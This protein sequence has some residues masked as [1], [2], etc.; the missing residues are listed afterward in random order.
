MEKVEKVIFIGDVNPVKFLGVNDANLNFLKSRTST[1][2]I[3]RG[4][5][6]RL[7]GNPEEVELISKVIYILK[8]EIKKRGEIEDCEVKEMMKWGLEHGAEEMGDTKDFIITPKRRIELKTPNQK[9][10]IKLIDENDVVI[11]IGP[12][13]TGKTYLAVASAINFLRKNL[14]ERVILT[15]PAVEAG[16]SLGFLPGDFQEKINPYLTPLYDALYAL[17]TPE[18]IK[19]YIDTRVIEIAPL[20]YMRGRTFSDAF[21]ILDEAQNSKAVQMKMFLTRLG[22]R[23]K[24]VLTG[25]I[26][27]IDLPGNEASGLVEIQSVLKG[28]KGIAFIYFTAEDVV[29]HGLV[30]DIVNAYE[31]FERK[32]HH[33]A[34]EKKEV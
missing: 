30:K 26:T 12:A 8:N 25:D 7:R 29:R 9:E 3:V 10:Y 34:Q 15:R 1:Q 33:S 13:G 2:I 18:T 11:A 31:R 14:V 20:A 24:L 17:L 28:V 27:Q 23:S 21:V 16:E 5:E 19:R 6:L 32:N 4:D 22:P